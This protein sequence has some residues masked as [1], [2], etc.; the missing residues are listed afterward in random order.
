MDMVTAIHEAGHAWAYRRCKMPLRY[1]TIRPRDA[2][3]A[4]ICR[5]WK[6]RRMDIGAAVLIAVAGPVAQAM[7]AQLTDT[8]E[9]DDVIWDD[10]VVRA[11]WS[12]GGEDHVDSLGLLDHSAATLGIRSQ[13][14]DDWA[15]ITRLAEALVEEHTVD[16][17]RAFELLGSPC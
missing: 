7:L 13:M 5:P 9:Y 1:V 3:T 6:P 17:K 15:A 11:V 10:Y 12:G 16:G 8:Y 14:Q 2:L 4:G